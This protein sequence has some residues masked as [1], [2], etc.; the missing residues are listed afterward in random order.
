MIFSE[1]EYIPARLFPI[2][3]QIVLVSPLDVDDVRVLVQLRARG[4]QV[5]VISPDPVSFELN[6]LTK[7]DS[8]DQAARLLRMERDLLIH[9]LQRAG[10]QVLDWN[11]S[12]PFDQVVKRRLGRPP[13][14]LRVLGGSK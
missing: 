2:H 4:Y 1:L 7:S 11:T 9:K 14:I 10:I 8:V 12:Q 6:Y 13:A 5:M 3:S